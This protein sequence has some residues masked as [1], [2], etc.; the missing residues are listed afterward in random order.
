MFDVKPPLGAPL[1]IFARG[2]ILT[3]FSQ[4]GTTARQRGFEVRA[5]PLLGELPMAIEPYLPVCQLCRCQLHYRC[6]PS[7]GLARGEPRIR[8]RWTCLHLSGVRGV[9]T[10]SVIIIKLIIKFCLFKQNPKQNIFACNMYVVICKALYI[11]C[12]CIFI[13]FPYFR[14]LFF[15]NPYLY[16]I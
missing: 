5:L 8:Y 6:Y 13:K 15:C 14:I 1:L 10:E 4:G 2:S 7:G 3:Y 16:T 11:K 12:F 9:D